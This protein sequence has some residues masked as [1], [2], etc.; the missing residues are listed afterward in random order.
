M[1]G[2]YYINITDIRFDLDNEV[3]KDLFFQWYDQSV[4]A[5]MKSESTINYKN[6]VK[7]KID[8]TSH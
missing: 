5:A 7:F 3:P 2:D 1:F 6:F 8:S 4:E